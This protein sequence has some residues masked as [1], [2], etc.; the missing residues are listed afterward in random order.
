MGQEVRL[1]R[2]ADLVQRT[3]H[4][5]GV[6]YVPTRDDFFALDR[7]VHRFVEGLGQAD[8]RGAPFPGW[9]NLV[10]IGICVDLDGG[11]VEGPYS[12]VSFIG[13]FE[14]LPSISRLLVLNVLV[15]GRCKLACAYCHADDLMKEYAGSEGDGD[16]AAII[17]TAQNLDSVVGVVTGGDPAA[18][19]ERAVEAIEKLAGKKKIVID[20]SGAGDFDALLPAIEATSAHVR[21][22]VDGPGPANHARGRAPRIFDA[23]EYA[24]ET[25]V[26]RRIPVTVQSVVSPRNNQRSAWEQTYEWLSSIGVRNWVIH[27]AI[28]AGKN[29]SRSGGP[30]VPAEG[31]RGELKTFAQT[32]AREG[33]RSMDLR[34]TD[35]SANP[36]SVLL[37]AGP[38]H[39]FTEG[40][41]K[42]GKVRLFD[43]DSGRVDQFKALWHYV[44]Q[45]GHAERYLNYSRWRYG[46]GNLAD[47]ALECR[48]PDPSKD[49]DVPSVV[50]TEAKYPVVSPADLRP[51]LEAAG[52]TMLRTSTQRDEYYDLPDGTL[53]LEDYAVRV[54]TVDERCWFAVKAPRLFQPTA[55]SS[56][57]YEF[58]VPVG[59]AGPA[60][61]ALLDRGLVL[62]WVL[63]KRRETWRGD[64][65]TVEIDEVPVIGHFV[66]VEA[67]M[68]VLLSTAEALGEALGPP[69]RRNYKELVVAA[70]E[71]TLGI[72][73][74]VVGATFAEGLVLRA[75]SAP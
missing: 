15:T 23:A 16:L 67:R 39:L 18:A 46:D 14:E 66:E 10:K 54:R 41:A 38:G 45:Y 71:A 40:Y 42:R 50:E 70:A 34:I 6:V 47:L 19:P 11:V 1:R 22:S 4:F 20:T 36:N 52:L 48:P 28:A 53:T 7:S 31:T 57:R 32:F 60:R 65:V 56:S 68:Q 29:A 74:P 44:D 61:Q 55:G 25:C 63:D 30:G 59:E 8:Y 26:A 62:S 17:S 64:R 33:E 5:G 75:A 9:E 13:A 72:D 3:E 21:V 43:G 73:P 58:E 35:T 27:L 2:K 12:G 24:I 37:V 49:D 69:E 51:R